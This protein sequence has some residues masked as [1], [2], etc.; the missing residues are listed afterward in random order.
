MELP[1]N[2][3]LWQGLSLSSYSQKSKNLRIML[4]IDFGHS[5]EK[6]AMINRHLSIQKVFG[7][8][9]VGFAFIV[10]PHAQAATLNGW[11]YAIASF[12][13]GVSGDQIGGGTYEFYSIAI[14]DTDTT[15]TVA[16]NANLPLTGDNGTTWGDLFFNFTGQTFKAASDAEQLFGVHFATVGSD[17]SV[18]ELGLYSNV[19]AKSVT[20]LNNGFLNLTDYSDRVSGNNNFGDLNALSP[21]FVEQQTGSGV[22]LN[23]IASGIK[24]ADITPLTADALTANGLNF[25]AFG[26]IG[27]QTFGFQFNKPSGF[28]GSFIA[29]V[30][31]ECANDGLVIQSSAAPEPTTLLGLAIAASGIAAARTKRIAKTK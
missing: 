1:S 27:S 5:S 14:Q 4:W 7:V 28:T 9:A 12:T 13:N 16:F 21:Y 8:A 15:F 30:F 10:Q 20:A 11:D 31:A 23:A 25:G 26:A 17:S 29:N 3:S 18:S 22:V 19:T 24:V 6:I 2:V